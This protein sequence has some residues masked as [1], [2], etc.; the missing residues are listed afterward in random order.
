[1][2]KAETGVA[3]DAVVLAALGMLG[4]ARALDAWLE[5]ACSERGPD[6]LA[7]DDPALLAALGLVAVR[8]NALRWLAEAAEPPRSESAART[9]KPRDLLR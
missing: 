4:A 5:A 6:A 2:A 8:R 1:M 3:T 7:E 9:P